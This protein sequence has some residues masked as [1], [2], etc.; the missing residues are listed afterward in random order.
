[1]KVVVTYAARGVLVGAYFRGRFDASLHYRGAGGE[2]TV[3]VEG[4][5]D[6]RL[7]PDDGPPAHV[8]NA[9]GG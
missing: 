7:E 6:I 9:Q 8:T 5:F 1:M 3:D 2:A 4:R